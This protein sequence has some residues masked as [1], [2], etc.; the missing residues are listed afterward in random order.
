MIASQ[1]SRLRD[2]VRRT[3][4]EPE[5]YPTG[6]ANQQGKDNRCVIHS[7]N[8]SIQDVAVVSVNPPVEH[9]LLELRMIAGQIVPYLNAFGLVKER[10]PT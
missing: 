10:K 6:L 5:K 4:P 2:R 3:I 7:V 8:N 1:L 9:P